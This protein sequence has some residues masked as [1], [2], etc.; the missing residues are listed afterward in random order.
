MISRATRM[1]AHLRDM[2]TKLIARDQDYVGSLETAGIFVQGHG[3]ELADTLD[4]LVSENK[5]LRELIAT[6]D[7]V[8]AKIDEVDRS[9][10]V[11]NGKPTS[12]K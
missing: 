2:T 4:S 8:D 5:R 3:D 12:V 10:L 1:A 9:R 6:F 7:K 11:V